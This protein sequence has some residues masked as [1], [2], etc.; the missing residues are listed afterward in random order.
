MANAPG[1]RL[2][3]STF[4][5]YW[6]NYDRGAISVGVG[7]PGDNLVY[8]WAD[9]EPIEAIRFAGLSA[10]DKH[11]AYRSLRMHPVLHP[12]PASPPPKQQ[13][14]AQQAWAAAAPPGEQQQPQPEQPPPQQPQ[15]PSLLECCQAALRQSLSPGSVCDVLQVADCL[16]P[17]VDGLRRWGWPVGF[18]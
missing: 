2:S 1:A 3:A 11:V 14:A 17:V 13:R 16:A 18:K 9:P 10:W 15:P 5:R 4:T 7:E 8:C 6:L 12:P